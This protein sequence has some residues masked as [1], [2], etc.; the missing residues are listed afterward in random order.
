M[1]AT[2]KKSTAKR[3]ASKKTPTLN[4]KLQEAA[5]AA[6]GAF[7]QVALDGDAQRLLIAKSTGVR[8]GIRASGTLAD[9]TKFGVNI[10]QRK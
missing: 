8:A 4:P 10:S 3:S 1:A 6:L 9:G 7:V 5:S 2:S